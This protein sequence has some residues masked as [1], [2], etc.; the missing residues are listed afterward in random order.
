MFLNRV[1]NLN[2]K[3][4]HFCLLHFHTFYFHIYLD[5]YLEHFVS[6]STWH[7]G[8]ISSKNALSLLFVF[9]RIAPF[10]LNGPVTIML[11]VEH[12]RKYT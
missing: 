1:L 5:V 11:I 10:L 12:F 7:F 2:I 3:Y 9:P 8:N 4:I 6:D